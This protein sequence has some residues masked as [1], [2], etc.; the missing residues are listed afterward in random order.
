MT[1]TTGAAPPVLTV[2]RGR[3]ARTDADV[4]LVAGSLLWLSLLLMAYWWAADA[5]FQDLTSWETGL[6]STGRLTGLVASDLLL[7][8]VL[9]MARLPVLERS[10]G[11]DRLAHLHRLVGFTSFNLMVTHVILIVWGYAGGSLPHLPAETW[12]MTLNDPGMLLAVAGTFCLVMVVATSIRAARAKLRYESWHLLHLYAYLGVGLALPHQLWTGQQFIDSTA[13]TVF[14]WSAWAITAAAILVFRV[15]IPTWRNLHHR[16]HVT[17]VVSEGDGVFSVHLGGRNLDRLRAEAGQ[18]FVWRFLS[19]EGRTRGNPYSLSA[20]PSR[21]G[22]R[23]TVKE[24]GDQSRRLRELAPGTPVLFEGPYGR[25]GDRVRTRDRIALIGAGVGITPLRA[26]AEGL[27]YAPGDAVMLH[28]YRDRPLMQ[29]ELEDLA[30][31]R[32]LNVLWLPGARRSDQS[33]LGAHAGEATDVAALRFWVPDIAE[34]DTYVCGPPVWTAQ[35]VQ[36]LRAAGVSPDQIHL[37][38]FSW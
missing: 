17:S 20:A 25:L 32:G 18:F 30:A 21:D 14:W 11:Q 34:R 22:L 9:L 2:D 38:S 10:F 1:A 26:L 33:W 12:R 5:G 35:V 16:V 7:V 3:R 31:H 29:R 19:G 24:V 13:K 8:Q 15:A 23:I 6:L 4:R 28:R 37:E 36:S 27:S